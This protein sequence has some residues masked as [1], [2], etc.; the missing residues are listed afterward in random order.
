M[1][2]GLCCEFMMFGLVIEMFV[3]G[4]GQVAAMGLP[5]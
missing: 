3:F 1:H 2:D 5:V 4:N